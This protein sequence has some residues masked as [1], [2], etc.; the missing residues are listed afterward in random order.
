MIRLRHGIVGLFIER[1]L[2]TCR[3][4]GPAAWAKSRS[5]DTSLLREDPCLLDRTRVQPS[6][7]RE[8]MHLIR[9][10]SSL[11][12]CSLLLLRTLDEQVS[13]MEMSRCQTYV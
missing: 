11:S 5:N 1:G 10:M 12:A 3:E 4:S 13:L 9:P 8:R 6:E 7:S 2:C